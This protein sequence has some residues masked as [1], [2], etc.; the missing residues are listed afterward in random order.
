[1]DSV[2]SFGMLFRECDTL[3]VRHAKALN[4]SRP[5]FDTLTTGPDCS[6][7]SGIKFYGCKWSV[8]HDSEIAYTRGEGL[9]FHN[10]EYGLAYNNSLHDNPTNLYCDNSARIVIRNN[11]NYAIEGNTRNWRTCPADT[12]HI[13]GSN[14]ILLANEGACSIGGP[15]YQNCR[16]MCNLLGR[17]YPNIDS[18]FI[19]N[20]VFINTT[21]ALSLWQGVTEVLQGYNCLRNIFFYH[22]TIVGVVGDPTAN[23][24]GMIHA[25]F[26]NFHNTAFNLGF[27][28]VENFHVYGNIISYDYLQY[29]KVQIARVVLDNLL[30]SPFQMITQ[31]NRLIKPD[32][33]FSS[34]DLIDSTMPMSVAPVIDSVLHYLQPDSGKRSLLQ[35]A[36]ATPWVIKDY[37]YQK[38]KDTTNIGALEFREDSVTTGN[39]AISRYPS[40]E[41]TIY[42]NPVD[43]SLVIHSE[44]S[45]SKPAKVTCLDISGRILWETPWPVEKSQLTLPVST[46]SAGF[47]MISI[48]S[49]EGTMEVLRFVKH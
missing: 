6:W 20:N 47:Y 19:H 44:Y 5:G 18:I 49:P 36:P 46:M 4:G 8:I 1:M 26:P 25:F 43:H 30:P 48:S 22:N 15:V 42:P 9:N 35:F 28:T 37:L 7:P 21:P 29:P 24:T 33:R 34:S 12:F 31:N 13:N 40:S 32:V 39:T 45:A 10:S 27:A 23:N 3:L 11:F 17:S 41:F 2:R 38:R 14:G 16:T